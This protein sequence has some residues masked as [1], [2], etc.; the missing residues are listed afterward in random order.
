MIIK[1]RKKAQMKKLERKIAVT[2]VR[3]HIARFHLVEE[4][5]EFDIRQEKESIVRHW[6][7]IVRQCDW[8][9][10]EIEEA[11]VYVDVMEY[12]GDALD[13]VSHDWNTIIEG[14]LIDVFGE[15][16]RKELVREVLKGCL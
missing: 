10:E 14:T 1:E 12:A 5:K 11:D 6:N 8:L 4:G 3:H 2:F 16:S 15:T 7:F 13:A 9:G